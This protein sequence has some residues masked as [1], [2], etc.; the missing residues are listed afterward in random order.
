MEDVNTKDVGPRRC[1][2]QFNSAGAWRGGLQFDGTTIPPEFLQ[3][4]DL[5]CRLADCGTT[6][7]VVLCDPIASGHSVLMHWSRESGW[8]PTSIPLSGDAGAALAAQ[9]GAVGEQLVLHIQHTGNGDPITGQ[10]VKLDDWLY[11]R[12]HGD[13]VT[14][15]SAA[16]TEAKPAT[17][18]QAV[19]IDG[20]EYTVPM[21]VTAEMLRL[22]LEAKPAQDAVD[23]DLVKFARRWEM[24][25]YMHTR[26]VPFSVYDHY[27]GNPERL[28]YAATLHREYLS[29]ELERAAISAKKAVV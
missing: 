11:A 17:E 21:P 28:D 16:P 19:L 10:R 12:A 20:V 5:M 4:A 26:G 1:E 15:T 18:T 29:G 23:A 6:M 2:L 9:P 7:R 27:I 13:V 22:H 24:L 14:L 3:S 25:A 8:V